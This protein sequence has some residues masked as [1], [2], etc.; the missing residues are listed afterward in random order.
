M[1]VGI[2]IELVMD[3]NNSILDRTLVVCKINEKNINGFHLH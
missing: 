3:V 2:I 1:H